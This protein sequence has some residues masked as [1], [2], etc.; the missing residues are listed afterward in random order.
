MKLKT[1]LYRQV[2]NCLAR[3][4]ATTVLLV[5][6]IPFVAGAQA[7]ITNPAVGVFGGGIN[8]TARIDSTSISGVVVSAAK[9]SGTFLGNGMLRL[10]RGEGNTCETVLETPYVA[11]AATVTFPAFTPRLRR[12]DFYY[13]QRYDAVTIGGLDPNVRSAQMIVVA[14]NAEAGRVNA[15][16]T[17]R[18]LV[19]RV[20]GLASDGQLR[21]WSNASLITPT[22]YAGFPASLS[23]ISFGNSAACALASGAVWCAGSNDVGQLGDGTT[24]ARAAPV[25]VVGL[26]A[27]IADVTSGLNTSCALS[28]GS[29]WCWGTNSYGEAT[30]GVSP[31]SPTSV[32]SAT[33]VPSLGTD[34]VK[35]VLGD[36]YGCSLKANG[37][38]FCWGVNGNG[39]LGNSVGLDTRTV[40]PATAVAGVVA[41][42]LTTHPLAQH[43]C[44]TKADFSVWCWG[45]NDYAQLGRGTASPKQWQ[46]AKS[47]AFTQS[48]KS[49]S[50]ARSATCIITL[51][52]AVAC[53]GE[54]DGGRLGS[55]DAVDPQT[56]TGYLSYTRVATLVQG[57]SGSVTSAS[58]GDGG[59]C[60]SLTDGS[61]RCSGS[62][63]LGDGSTNA[64]YHP[65]RGVGFGQ[66]QSA[67]PAPTFGTSSR[68]DDTLTFVYRD[69]LTSADA[70]ITDHRWACK[71]SNGSGVPVGGNIR[72]NEAAGTDH[73]VSAKI[74][75]QGMWSCQVMYRTANGYS[76][77]S[78]WV[79][80]TARP[81]VVPTM[82]SAVYDG[83]YGTLVFSD[84]LSPTKGPIIGLSAVCFV[85]Y[86][87][88]SP[89][90]TSGCQG[91]DT[92]CSASSVVLE[93]AGARHTIRL[94]LPPGSSGVSQ[95]SCRAGYT[96]YDGPSEN[97]M[98]NFLLTA[99]P[100]PPPTVNS[101][102]IIGNTGTLAFSDNLPASA[103]T[104]ST[105]VWSCVRTRDNATF[106]GAA[107]INEPA[108]GTHT[109]NIPLT[110]NDYQ[111]NPDS[112]ACSVKVATTGLAGPF[113]AAYTVGPNSP[114]VISGFT[115]SVTNGVIS[116]S[117][118]IVD[119]DG[120]LVKNLM[121][122]FGSSPRGTDCSSGVLGTWDVPRAGGTINFTASSANVG[123][124]DLLPSAT[125]IYGFVRGSG[126]NGR[127]ATIVDAQAT[128]TLWSPPT[129]STYSLVFE[130]VPSTLIVN[131][132]ADVTVR[133]VDVFGATASQFTGPIRV[134]LDVE[135]VPFAFE[136]EAGAT[137]SVSRVVRLKNGVGVIRALRF[138]EPA[139]VKLIGAT[140]LNGTTLSLSSAIADSLKAAPVTAQMNLGGSS[141]A[142]S[143]AK[144]ATSTYKITWSSNG[145]AASNFAS[146][147]CSN[148]FQAVLLNQQSTVV[149]TIVPPAC[150]PPGTIF[151]VSGS[152]APGAYSI[153]FRRSGL[154]L[155]RAN[156]GVD[157]RKG[158]MVV[159]YT[160]SQ[161]AQNIDFTIATSVVGQR[162]VILIPG[163]FGSTTDDNIAN[164]WFRPTLPPIL[165]ARVLVAW[166][167][168]AC[169]SLQFFDDLILGWKTL[170]IAIK[171]EGYRVKRV[172]WD[173]RLA[174]QDAAKLYL[175][176]AIDAAFA[177]S[178]QLPVDVV[179][180]SMG[181]LVALSALRQLDSA[182][183]TDRVLMLGSP[184]AGSANAYG[185]LQ[186]ADPYGLDASIIRS[187]GGYS[188]KGQVVSCSDT[189]YSNV[190]DWLYQNQTGSRLGSRAGTVFA[191]DVLTAYKYNQS[192]QLRRS[193]FGKA[194]TGG[195]FLYPD[196]SRFKFIASKPASW[197]G[198]AAVQN[199]GPNNHLLGL[200]ATASCT[201][202]TRR[203]V[204]TNGKTNIF[205]SLSNSSIYTIRLLPETR[206]VDSSGVLTHSQWPQSGVTNK[207]GDGTVPVDGQTAKLA[208]WLGVS[209]STVDTNC[210]LVRD[211]GKHAD[212]TS[213]DALRDW[214]ITKLGRVGPPVAATDFGTK[215]ASAA[216]PQYS[217]SFSHPTGRVF[218]DVSGVGRLGS[219]IS[220]G[221]VESLDVDGATGT[222]NTTGQSVWLQLQKDTF[223]TVSASYRLRDTS[224]NILVEHA[225]IATSD[226]AS[227]PASI[228]QFLARP[229]VGVTFAG[230]IDPIKPSV[231]FEMEGPNPPTNLRPF[232]A[233]NTT[234]ISWLAPT[235]A[236]NVTRYHVYSRRAQA[237]DWRFDA[238]VSSF[239][240][241]T[242]L[243]FGGASSTV[244]ERE[245]LVLAVD[246]QAR[247]SYAQSFANNTFGLE[248]DFSFGMAKVGVNTLATSP[249]T[250]SI[251][252]V[253]LPFT[254][255]GGEYSLDGAAWSSL[256]G[257][258]PPYATMQLRGTSPATVGN[259]QSVVLTT[260]GVPYTFA[261]QSVTPP[262]CSRATRGLVDVGPFIRYLEG[263]SDTPMLSGFVPVAENT[264]TNASNL[265]N[266]YVDN[267]F[268]YDF[269]GD[270]SMS[271]EIDGLLYARYALGF[272]GL[273]LVSG[274]AVGT[275]RTTAQIE[276]ALSAC[277]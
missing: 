107:S 238:D 14:D 47:T 105:S 183:K 188:K 36:F 211:Y 20:C 71:S 49:M 77:W 164:T 90:G 37:G 197:Y 217:I 223:A 259:V 229:N 152:V 59:V 184:L 25:A 64:S 274:I 208:D 111:Q 176:P 10:C 209:Q 124:S 34:N 226:V 44:V 261:I 95:I 86:G 67:L 269:N 146:K 19:G 21:C 100:T 257:T 99:T 70:P 63:P 6:S 174:P 51:G 215:V 11:G 206:E 48:P 268:A 46:P 247:Y 250:P 225:A 68:T 236:S 7:V 56:D 169:G 222:V 17:G 8:I 167:Q 13:V 262:V 258:L 62:G 9:T 148:D 22:L 272:R 23:K 80:I 42:T 233:V 189:V 83:N 127:D 28:A 131:Q 132:T 194:A 69:G 153:E 166:N 200:G 81:T 82:V 231:A 264:S 143:V 219:D 116:G 216:A 234:S 101:G 61:V 260:N 149:Q 118:S 85:G 158:N 227:N 192:A 213:N 150:T 220:D 53:V 74:E 16:Q 52:D 177:E 185:L 144:G 57:V 15:V 78:A 24:T 240:L 76:P 55:D 104:V 94:P 5:C 125:T 103:G 198:G 212:M 203:P 133:L 204:V 126:G 72:A 228:K 270:G 251:A 87:A 218:W 33:L 96:T 263:V 168:P 205:L 252:N 84:N 221:A 122:Y 50:F 40:Y 193:T 230:N 172:A 276:A 190:A 255:S 88:Y 256:P 121:V 242:V 93:P 186:V 29:V 232:P 1:A 224:A 35:V 130:Q 38:V 245:I 2:R 181:G 135:A 178:G 267:F 109:I 114:P 191:C 142:I 75:R 277:Q 253:P 239:T 18:G 128:N 151:T 32:L 137:A 162:V 201:N 4:S 117:F 141:S 3:M 237:N 173:W 157:T 249:V 271:P 248:P 91:G 145:G 73:T 179:A 170:E 147:W 175:K 241:S 266:Q 112:Y 12:Q 155:G 235:S 196:Y 89:S 163:I 39:S 113:S 139:V 43:V 60:V 154:A 119:P 97:A 273:G 41:T 165:C 65:V 115:F 54:N 79:Q 214:V 138:S 98:A 195:F 134:G 129:T 108:G 160:A 58:T 254:I 120:D 199:F 110:S 66:A 159:S 246:A 210:S 106:S 180:H 27:A 243:P 140:T 207:I 202:L 244:D 30:G 92:Q 123:C 182:Q 26:P 31:G 275:A 265:I 156:S 171:G 45:M 187:N 161:S 136:D 102:R